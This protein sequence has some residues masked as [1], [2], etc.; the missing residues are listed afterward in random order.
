VLVYGAAF[1]AGILSR[2]GETFPEQSAAVEDV[3]GRMVDLLQPF[4]EFAYYHHAQRGKVKLKTVLP[5]LTDEDY[6]DL[7][8]KDG[9]TANFAYRYL[10]SMAEDPAAEDTTALMGN[11]VRYCTMDTLAMVKIMGEFQSIVSRSH[12]EP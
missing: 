3:A 1:E 7:A 5:I 8:V 2:L 9:Y 4:N 12:G 10:V 6:S 11:L